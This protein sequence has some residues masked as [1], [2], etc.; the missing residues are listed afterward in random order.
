[1][2]KVQKAERH[3]SPPAVMF[4]VL[5]GV[6]SLFADIT[7]EGARSI[8][9]PFLAFLGAN[10]AIAALIFGRLFDRRGVIVGVISVVVS[11][12]FAPLILFGS[13]FMSLAGMVV[14]GIGMGAQE[15]VMERPLQK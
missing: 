9:G 10:A 12:F 1:V 3:A 11:A 4:V 14:W 5:L 6:V 7:Y 15:S 13:F 2:V 8:T